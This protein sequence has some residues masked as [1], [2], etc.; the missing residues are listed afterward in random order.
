[1]MMTGIVS[2]NLIDGTIETR[3]AATPYR[4]QPAFL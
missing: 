1:M 3:R 2:E 4:N